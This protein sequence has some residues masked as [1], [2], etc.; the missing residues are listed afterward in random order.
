MLGNL[1]QVNI[2]KT[3]NMV[4]FNETCGPSDIKLS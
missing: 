3:V 2:A 4:I 1:L